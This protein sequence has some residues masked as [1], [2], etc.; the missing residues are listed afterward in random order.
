MHYNICLYMTTELNFAYVCTCIH[1]AFIPHGEM[2]SYYIISSDMYTK[3][4]LDTMF[5]Q[6][7]MYVYI[8]IYI[9]IYICT[10]ETHL[11]KTCSIVMIAQYIDTY[12]SPFSI[13]VQSNFTS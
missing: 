3:L 12:C 6:T 5:T 7:F 4:E 2:V 13:E 1:A 10:T 9:Y 11:R 8:Y